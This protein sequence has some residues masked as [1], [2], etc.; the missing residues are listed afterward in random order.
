[1]LAT[2]LSFLPGLAFGLAFGAAVASSAGPIAAETATMAV[3]ANFRSTAETLR[4]EFEAESGHALVIA[5]G[6][7]GQLYAQIVNG[8]PYDGFLAADQ[9]R[10]E[11]AETDGLA[12]AGSRFTY[13][14]GRLALI[15]ADPEAPV[16]P[17]AL[18]KATGAVAIANP[19]TA[20][21][22]A[23]AKAALE[24]LGLWPALEGRIAQAQNVGG[25]YAAVASGAAEFGFV[26]LSYVIGPDGAPQ[27]AYWTPPEVSAATL[28][29]DA[30]LLARGGD[31]AAAIAFLDYLRGASAR[32]LI[33]AQGYDVE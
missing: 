22:G 28:R 16:D 21:Y 17:E 32:A 1:M 11:R 25:A 18:A 30:V 8:A 2:R 29:Q 26:A 27:R 14:I 19:R 33:R 5:A 12:V 24:R 3:A 9:A 15:A 31:N 6:S 13:A 7:T 10:P 4:E 23:A 20:P